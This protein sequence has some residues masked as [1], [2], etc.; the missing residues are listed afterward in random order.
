MTVST[1]SAA[2]INEGK[3]EHILIFPFMAHGHTIPLLYLAAELSTRNLQVTVIT[4]Q[5]NA[6]SL[7]RQLPSS[8]HLTLFPFPQSPLLP[9]GVESTDLLPSLD[10]HSAFVAATTLLRPNFHHL[11][12]DLHSRNSLPLCVISD[13]FLPWTL[14]VCRLFSVPRIVFHGMSAFSLYLCKAICLHQPQKLAGVIS[15]DEPFT[16][17]GAPLDFRVTLS[18]VPKDLHDL[19]DSPDPA[20]QFII[21]AGCS[22]VNSWG[23]IVNSFAELDGRWHKPLESMYVAGARSWLVGP[24]SL[25]SEASLPCINGGDEC[26]RWLNGKPKGSVVY[27]SFGTQAHV[28]REQLEEVAHG[29]EMAG[30]DYLWVVRDVSFRPP[31]AAGKKGKIVAWAPQGAVLLNEA[32]GGFVSHCGWN[33]ALESI[34]AGKP[35]LA[36]PMIAEQ[37][38]NAKFLAEELR[39]GMRIGNAAGDQNGVVSR[40]VVEKGVR[41][42]MADGEM[43]NK[44]EMFGRMARNAVRDGGS[45]R[46]TLTELIEELRGVQARKDIGAGNGPGEMKQEKVL[47]QMGWQDGVKIA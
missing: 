6:T 42:M 8:V 1:A 13:F 35:M 15:D 34:A 47:V 24:L 9:T 30:W 4:T 40:E 36:W 20:M 39:V 10:L 2:A 27:V 19:S 41:E 28:E 45:S 18:D 33:S 38:L 29:L 44:A 37:S 11:L 31:E 5:G 3:K 17:P 26:L 25:L 7:R 23:V 43:R 22:D 16:V 14:D 21:E 46:Q 12:L 32:V